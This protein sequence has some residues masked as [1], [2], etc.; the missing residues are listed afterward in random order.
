MQPLVKH[1]LGLGHREFA[2]L[3]GDPTH[4]ERARGRLDGVLDTLSAA[5]IRLPPGNII[6]CAFSVAAGREG[7]RRAVAL[8]PRPTAVVACT[9]QL[10][11]GALA[12]ARR[13]GLAVPE[14]L[15]ITGFDDVEFA[16]LLEPALT[17]V[18]LPA[19]DMG[20]QAAQRMLHSIEAGPDDTHTELATELVIR[21]S[22]GPA[23]RDR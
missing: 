4:N 23:W 1:L 13:L 3:T 22:T 5:D 18:R 16:A 15:S 14:R 17:T 21:A 12:E 20:R 11:A 6:V 2:V 19:G 10:A 9:D 7:L 8:R